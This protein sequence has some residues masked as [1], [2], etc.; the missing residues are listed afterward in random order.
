MVINQ[1]KVHY[2]YCTYVYVKYSVVELTT[3]ITTVI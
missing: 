2:G 3:V 1:Q